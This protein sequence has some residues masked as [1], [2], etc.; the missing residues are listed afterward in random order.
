[1][2]KQNIIQSSINRSPW[3]FGFILIP[4]LLVCFSLLPTVQ[5]RPSPTPS[6]TQ[7][8]NVVNTPNVN[9]ANTPSVSVVGT[10]TVNLGGNN[11][12]NVSN[13]ASAPALVR[14]VDTAARTPFFGHIQL[15][16]TA[17]EFNKSASVDIPAGKM[18]VVEF[19]SAFADGGDALV[20]LSIADGAS[21]NTHFLAWNLPV[22]CNCAAYTV[23]EQIRM[24]ATSSIVMGIIR[25]TA[26]GETD[27]TGSVTGYLVDAP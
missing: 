13:S 25:G 17:G 10:P 14:D 12:I 7:D 9:V 15:V 27:V 8:V 1:M 19:T 26:N 21:G 4:F 16:A 24:Y 11:S 18:L 5:A 23:S 3:R 6:P 20:Q 22:G 2:N